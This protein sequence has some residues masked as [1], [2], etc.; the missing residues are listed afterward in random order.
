M[1]FEE[2]EQYRQQMRRHLEKVAPAERHAEQGSPE[3]S[4][5]SAEGNKPESRYGQGFH[6]RD[7]VMGGRPAADSRPDRPERPDKVERFS[8]DHGR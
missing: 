6:T 3:R 2:Y 4:P 5:A 7:Q 8:H 1:S